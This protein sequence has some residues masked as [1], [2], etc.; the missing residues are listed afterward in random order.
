MCGIA[1]FVGNGRGDAPGVLD[2][3][4]AC[5]QHR[6]PDARGAAHDREFAV[7]LGHARLSIL[8]HGGGAQPMSTSDGRL[9]V[10]FNGEIY[11]HVELRAELEKAGHEFV[12]DH[13]DTEVLLYAYR[14]WGT[15]FVTRLNGMWA[16]ALFDRSERRLLLSRDRFGQK[17]LYYAEPRAGEIVFASELDALCVHP[18]VSGGLSL[19]SVQKYF[20]YG[21]VPAPHAIVEGVSKLPA[22]ANLTLSIGGPRSRVHRYWRFELEPEGP[23]D[24]RQREERDEG[25][26]EKFECAVRRRLVADVPVGVFLSGGIDS[27]AVAAV[28]ARE[29]GAVLETFSVGFDDPSFDESGFA[30][31]V[32][33]ELGTHHHTRRFTRTEL[34]GLTLSLARDLDEPMADPS[35]LPTAM[36][37]SVARKRVTVALGGD[38]ADELFAGY[39]PFRALALARGYARVVPRPVHRA[40][41]W[42]AARLPVAHHNMS[43]GFRLNRT[44]AGLSHPEPLW[45]ARWMGPLSPREIAELTGSPVDVETLYSEAIDA[46]EHCRHPSPIAH[47]LQ[48]Y[49]EL[50][51]QNDILAKVD[52]AS[53][54]CGLEVRSPFLDIDLVD[55]TRR[56]PLEEKFAGGQTKRIL[57]RA[58]APWLP[59]EILLRPKKGFGIPI[60]AWF[61]DDALSFESAPAALPHGDAML[62]AR[63]AEHRAGRDDHRLYLY[64]DWLLRAWADGRADID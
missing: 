57:K 56:L 7:H 9:Q 46:Y 26:R 55:F 40:I 35:L 3:M 6:G 29:C 28:A 1:G 45:N 58:F 4:V 22:G 60:G 5:L 11:N 2:R 42:L 31:R 18:D 37:S 39:D 36:L 41:R 64:A 8:D 24:A 52:R 62:E 32:A 38:G 43:F 44:L 17:P 49:T 48:F 54:R 53:M 59:R 20:A 61:R 23:L 27:S 12:S 34:E 63:R 30:A 13:S 51:L 21:Y 19:P 50:Y 14:E 16:F 25:L 33:G 10:V 47:S 15:N